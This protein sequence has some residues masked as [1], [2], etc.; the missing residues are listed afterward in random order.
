[1]KK[2]KNYLKKQ[3]LFRSVYSGTKESDIIYQKYFIKNLHKFDNNEL[4]LIK[5]LFKEYS[6]PEI[7]SI[8][9]KKIKYKKKFKNLFNKIDEI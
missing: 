4:E 7:L 2:V 3:I 1:M 8:F 5:D 6:D 9:S